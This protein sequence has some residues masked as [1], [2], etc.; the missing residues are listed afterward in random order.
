MTRFV[1]FIL[2]ALIFLP[3]AFAT[4][5]TSHKTKKK[6]TARPPLQSTSS[7]AKAKARSK[8]AAAAKA[9]AK[10]PVGKTQKAGAKRVRRSVS[11]WDVP[12]YADST[13]G[14]VIDGEDLQ[15]RRAAV[16]PWGR[17]TGRW[18]WPTR[19]RAAF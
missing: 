8:A 12:T 3:G 4:T 16:T 19:R 5:T 2:T 15:V 1:G 6:E 18:S 10:S 13:I 9:A 7:K 14:D 11:P 17:S